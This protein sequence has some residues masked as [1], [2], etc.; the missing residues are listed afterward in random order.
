MKFLAPWYIDQ[1]G[2]ARG[3]LY[4]IMSADH[5]LI[6]EDVP[7]EI[8]KVI[9]AARNDGLDVDSASFLEKHFE[10]KY[11]TAIDSLKSDICKMTLQ[12]RSETESRD[13]EI[14]RLRQIL[15]DNNI[16]VWTGQREC[17]AVTRQGS[18]F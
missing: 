5:C 3:L 16:N 9:V 18:L 6:C 13:G 17:E 12:F 15:K 8:A 7:L 1:Y 14:A 10:E 2:S 11:Q 4:R